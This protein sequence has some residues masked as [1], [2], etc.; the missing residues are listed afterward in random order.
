MDKLT[1]PVNDTAKALTVL[2]LLD[3]TTFHKQL[4]ADDD[5]IAFLAEFATLPDY[6]RFSVA[7]YLK[8]LGEP[9]KDLSGKTMEEKK[10]YLLAQAHDLPED[11]LEELIAIVKAF[12]KLKEHP[13]INDQH[14]KLTEQLESLPEHTQALLKRIREAYPTNFHLLFQRA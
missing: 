10:S 12:E 14:N 1:T 4:A 13:R 5:A 9:R 8:I 11:A 3:S 6:A 7:S 2:K